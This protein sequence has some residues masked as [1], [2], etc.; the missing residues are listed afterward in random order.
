MVYWHIR[1]PSIFTISPATSNCAY[2]S[3]STC[4]SIHG[5]L[6]SRCWIT[7]K[8]SVVY[9]KENLVSTNF[10]ATFFINYQFPFFLFYSFTTC[11]HRCFDCNL[12]RQKWWY[13][14]LSCDYC[15]STH[16]VPFDFVLVEITCRKHQD[17]FFIR[18]GT[19]TLRHHL[20]KFSSFF[21]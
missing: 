13:Q 10:F 1:D 12:L 18:W 5:L 19:N 4:W 3:Y 20:Q 14:R 8:S 9:G 16:W 15:Q 17:R 6:C 7:Q 11:I 2:S 21:I